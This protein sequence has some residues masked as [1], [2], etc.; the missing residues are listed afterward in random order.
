ML[1]KEIAVKQILIVSFISSTNLVQLQLIRATITAVV[2]KRQTTKFAGQDN[3]CCSR[4]LLYTSR[5]TSGLYSG[6]LQKLFQTFA[7]FIMQGHKYESRV[8]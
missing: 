3:C 6:K 2:C 8:R 7:V 1:H 5:L 4:Q